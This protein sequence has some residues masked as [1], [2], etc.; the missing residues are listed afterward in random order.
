MK[1]ETEQYLRRLIREEIENNEL[2]ARNIQDT[3]NKTKTKP[4]ALRVIIKIAN[5]TYVAD[6]AYED[7]S[8]NIFVIEATKYYN[9]I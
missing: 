5:K 3:I 1:K 6:K 8:K 4:S 9:K 2:S 7:T